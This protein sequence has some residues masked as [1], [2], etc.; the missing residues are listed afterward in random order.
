MAKD[1]KIDGHWYGPD[2]LEIEKDFEGYLVQVQSSLKTEFWIL[3]GNQIAGRLNLHH[4]LN[5]ELKMRG[6]HIGYG[7]STKF[8]NRGLATKALEEAL[9]VAKEKGFKEI[10][11]TCDDT[12]GGSIRVI[13]KNGGQL[14]DRIIVPGRTIHTR[15][16]LIK[17]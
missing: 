10:L 2:P 3:D 4:E 14:L 16:Y 17:I 9:G 13:E 6:G 11:I 7:I 15:R 1:L 12:N 8:R 5:D